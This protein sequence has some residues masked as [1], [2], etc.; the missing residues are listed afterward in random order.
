MNATRSIAIGAA[1]SLLLAPG[2]AAAVKT[3]LNYSNQTSNSVCAG[4]VEST[5]AADNAARTK[6]LLVGCGFEVRT[7]NDF[8]GS[9]AAA[10]S[11][12]AS[13][14]LSIHSNAGGGHGAETLK[15]WYANSATFASKIQ[16]ALIS[17]IPYQ[18]RG[19]KDGT[20]QGGRCR[21]LNYSGQTAALVEVVF[22]DCCV[23]SGYQGHPP[24]EA[25]YLVSASGRQTISTGLA[26]GIGNYHGIACDGST[27]PPPTTGSIKGVVYQS[28]DLTNHVA[29]ATVKLSTGATKTYDG[30]AVWSFDVPAGSNY[31][32]TA[33]AT[34]FQTATK[35]CNPVTAGAT[36]WCSIEITATPAPPTT[37][38]LRGV[39]YQDG[40]KSSHVAP[41]TVT[42]SNG[43]ATTYDGATEWS[44]TLPA[45]SY[46]LT[47]SAAGYQTRTGVTCPAVVAGSSAQCDVELQRVVVPDAGPPPVDA[48]TPLADAGTPAADGSAPAEDASAASADAAVEPAG[49]EVVEIGMMGCSSARGASAP[50]G[51]V[52]LV[53]VLST[54]RSRRRSR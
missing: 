13:S 22:H 12:G 24:S 4:G 26:K 10:A 21:V 51:L 38:V 30:S 50:L 29:P 16:S 45:A 52:A 14:F 6:T 2:Q 35:N 28:G 1:L 8:Y 19:V 40:D 17:K 39:V 44:F 25:A 54:L 41:A 31:S 42:L 3:F 9:N 47:V 48:A 46:T 23:N 37:G 53:L 20:C 11:W 5:Y 34:G 32:V 36:T 43:T 18:S 7:S 27:T 33:S 15:G 49:P